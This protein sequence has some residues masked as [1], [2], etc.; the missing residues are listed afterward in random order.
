MAWLNAHTFKTEPNLVL[1]KE[2][3]WAWGPD[4]PKSCRPRWAANDMQKMCR[5]IN[6]WSRNLRFH[7]SWEGRMKEHWRLDF[8]CA[9]KSQHWKR[10]KLLL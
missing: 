3:S 8:K 7:K 6:A 10:M 1:G 5:L 4:N 9:M 2:D